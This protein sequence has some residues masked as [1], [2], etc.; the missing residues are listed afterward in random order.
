MDSA[1]HYNH[2]IYVDIKYHI[3]LVSSVERCVELQREFPTEE[4]LPPPSII[5]QSYNF[6]VQQCLD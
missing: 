1:S 3:V 2:T 6:W 5:Q 4:N